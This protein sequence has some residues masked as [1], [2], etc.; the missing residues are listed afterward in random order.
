[1]TRPADVTRR[2]FARLLAQAGLLAGTGSRLHAMSQQTVS[3]TDSRIVR[4]ASPESLEADLKALDGFVTPVAKH[5]VRN[6]YPVPVVDTATWRLQVDGAVREPLA[7]SLDALQAMPAITRPVTLE[8]AGNGRLFLTP[9]VSGVQWGTGGVSTAEWT[10]VLLEHLLDRAGLLPDAV[11]VVAD[12]LD[13]GPVTGTPRPAGDVSY[14]RGLAVRE[15]VARGALVAYAMNGAPLPPAHGFPARL[16]VPGAYGM[17]AVKWLR[18]LMVTR[19]PFDGY[20]QTT[21]YAYW[22]RTEGWPQRKPLLGMHVKSVIAGPVADAQ[23]PRGASVEIRGFA[24]SEAPVT[25]VDVS[26][27]GGASWQRATLLD[28]PAPGAW[29]R[30][31][32]TWQTPDAAGT[33]TLMARATDG[34]GRVQ[35]MTR[36]ADY[37]T[38]VIHHVIPVPVV[39]A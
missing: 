38:Y 29:R 34:L 14:N 28:A 39:I 27:D 31:H 18:R 8:C 15:A 16:V 37:E 9:P 22:D 36:N 33:A 7:L 26:V 19:E 2:T 17:A 5:Y 10:G 3:P 35:P 11:D 1:M 24:W 20:W 25:R 21:D 13:A 4:S 30:W 6:H 23:V 32:S 12:G